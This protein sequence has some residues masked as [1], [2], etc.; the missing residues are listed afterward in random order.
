MPNNSPY[1]WAKAILFG[2]IL[3]ALALTGGNWAR[4]SAASPSAVAAPP[5]IASISP[6]FLNRSAADT[7]M[8][9]TGTNFGTLANTRVRFYQWGGNDN[10]PIELTPL[11]VN[12]GSI[13]LNL[14]STILVNPNKF[15]VVVIVYTVPLPPVPTV[16]AI[17]PVPPYPVTP[18]QPILTVTPWELMSNPAIFNVLRPLYL[19]RLYSNP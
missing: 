19:P 3:L 5:T 8:V 6:T 1:N 15:S 10:N 12:P 9:I 14:P 11:A 18:V 7:P 17:P 2:S 4:T 16:P 13:A